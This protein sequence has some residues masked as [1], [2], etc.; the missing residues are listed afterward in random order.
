VGAG[1][2]IVDGK[3][4][5]VTRMK[6]AGYRTVNRLEMVAQLA[7][8]MDIPYDLALSIYSDSKCSIQKLI[9]WITDPASLE[10]GQAP[11][12]YQ[13]HSCT[14]STEDGDF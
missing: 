9:A 12:Y 1:Y 10:G 4:G 7:V 3:D 6:V 2:V 13:G 5:Q 11:I 8:L 14:D